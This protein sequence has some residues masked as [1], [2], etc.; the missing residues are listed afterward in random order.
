M[1][2][3]IIECQQ[4]KRYVKERMTLV[5]TASMREDLLPRYCFFAA[6]MDDRTDRAAATH[7][8]YVYDF[9]ESSIWDEAELWADAWIA[10]RFGG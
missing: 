5:V 6:I 8:I 4:R 3:E 1:E 2:Q 10:E 9:D 7:W